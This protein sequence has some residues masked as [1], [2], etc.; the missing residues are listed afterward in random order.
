MGVS[1]IMT[2]A[3]ID[4]FA[5]LIPCRIA[6][7]GDWSDRY[8]LAKV[9]VTATRGAYKR[10]EWIETTLSRLVPRKAVHLRNGQYRIWAYRWSDE[11]GTETMPRV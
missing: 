3:Y 7:V 1:D 11:R 5:G 4:S 9:Q 8:S 2:L 10:G 6:A